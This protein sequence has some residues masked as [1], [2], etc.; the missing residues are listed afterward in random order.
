MVAPDS[1]TKLD[2]LPTIIA[3]SVT[4]NP[5]ISCS[6]ASNL[7]LGTVPESNSDAFNEVKLAPDTAGKVPVKEP[8]SVEAHFLIL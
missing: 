3:L 6:C 7:A 5:A 2:P 1:K 8:K 4:A